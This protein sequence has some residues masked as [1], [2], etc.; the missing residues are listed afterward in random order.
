MLPSPRWPL[1][2]VNN[3]NQ[4]WT[5]QFQQSS[6]YE[7]TE[8]SPAESAHP[9]RYPPFPPAKPTTK[10]LAASTSK[11]LMHCNGLDLALKAVLGRAGN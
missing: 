6:K 11:S 8:H 5:C 10:T 1:S 4:N 2:K 7:T 9:D 3:H